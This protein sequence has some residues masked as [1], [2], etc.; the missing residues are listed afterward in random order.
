MIVL[1][2]LLYQL[3][4][5]VDYAQRPQQAMAPLAARNVQGQEQVNLHTGKM[6]QKATNIATSNGLA[7]GLSKQFLVGD[8]KCNPMG[9]E[10]NWQQANE[11]IKEECRKNVIEKEAKKKEI[12]ENFMKPSPKECVKRMN[13]ESM[14]C[15][16]T[17]VV[18]RVVQKPYYKILLYNNVVELLVNNKVVLAAVVENLHYK[19]KKTKKH[20][21]SP[22]KKPTGQLEFNELGGLLKQKGEIPKPKKEDPCASCLEA[23]SKRES[24]EGAA[25]NCGG[26]DSMMEITNVRNDSFKDITN[27]ENEREREN[28]KD[29]SGGNNEEEEKVE[30]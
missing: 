29:K 13:T 19:V 20:V 12:L 28:S 23:L 25:G 6:L 4:K 5:A 30:E 3:S 26:C 16:T 27:M 24:E 15:H 2:P 21:D 1:L 22:L 9:V 8:Q 17:K 14:L 10:A 7:S 11:K 18:N